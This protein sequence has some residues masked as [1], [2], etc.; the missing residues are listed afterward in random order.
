MR[1]YLQQ[2]ALLC[3]FLLCLLITACK[4][5]KGSTLNSDVDQLTTNLENLEKE[6]ANVLSN[7]QTKSFENPDKLPS[8]TAQVE[9]VIGKIGDTKR[10]LTRNQKED[11]LTEAKVSDWKLDYAD[12]EQE[13][14][15]IKDQ[16]SGL[17]AV[18]K[19]VKDTDMDGVPDDVD[20]CLTERGPARNNGCPE[21][22][23]DSK[24]GSIQTKQ[25]R[26]TAPTTSN[27]TKANPITSSRPP[28]KE[29]KRIR[30]SD[31]D[32]LL[33]NVDKCPNEYGTGADGCPPKFDPPPAGNI[34]TPP[35][36]IQ[37]PITN[38]RPGGETTT[39]STSPI[40]NPVSSNKTT[41]NSSNS[42]S[43]IISCNS[44]NSFSPIDAGSACSEIEKTC[45][46]TIKPK[47]NVAFTNFYLV[48]D[49][50]G[51][52][53][54]KLVDSSGKKLNKR[55]TGNVNAGPGLSQMLAGNIQLQANKTYM[56]TVKPKS[57][58][59]LKTHSCNKDNFTHPD[60]ELS[61]TGEPFIYQINFCK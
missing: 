60:V 6:A 11:N 13:F 58:L 31:G 41:S 14:K 52:I 21:K 47:K 27:A 20:Q 59:K 32:G 34:Y 48:G 36:T 19:K 28:V 39:A 54:Y 38:S 8:L 44:S 10:V 23:L 43:T 61:F 12:I 45:G 18:V 1:P 3:F 5:G 9:D 37:N 40:S 46:L 53:E 16:E 25:T 35:T 26:Q 57:G 17:I 30:D 49:D 15:S 7:L 4:G 56:L 29:V 55:S 22:Q 50:N 42:S 2:V 33:D 24:P 51:R